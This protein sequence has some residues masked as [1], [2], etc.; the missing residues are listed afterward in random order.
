MENAREKPILYMQIYYSG[1]G[2]YSNSLEVKLKLYA[3]FIMRRNRW[4]QK[5]GEIQ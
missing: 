2:N 3:C 5:S 1:G 4:S